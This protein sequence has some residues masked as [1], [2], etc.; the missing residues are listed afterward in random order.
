MNV[1]DPMLNRAPFRPEEDALILSQVRAMTRADQSELPRLSLG[2]KRG[3]EDASTEGTAVDSDEATAGAVKWS[4]IAQMLPGRTDC[5]VWMRWRQLE[6]ESFQFIFS[7][8]YP[9]VVIR[10]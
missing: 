8:I 3:R 4:R 6:S 7:I 5:N 10:R 1:L 2:R 9:A